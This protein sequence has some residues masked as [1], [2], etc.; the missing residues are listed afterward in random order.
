MDAGVG[1]V[2]DGLNMGVG[3]DVVDFDVAA[4]VVFVVVIDVE[5][6]V[7]L[8]A[9]LFA[10]VAALSFNTLSMLTSAS[11]LL[12]SEAPEECSLADYTDVY[13]QTCNHRIA[14]QLGQVEG[15]LLSDQRRCGLS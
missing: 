15:A 2:V 4:L 6:V 8:V 3:A 14:K 12:L 10:A 1:V 9:V 11:L 5:A 7:V 13:S